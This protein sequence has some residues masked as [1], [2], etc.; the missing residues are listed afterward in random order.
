[1]LFG[2][3]IQIQRLIEMPQLCDSRLK[4]VGKALGENNQ[5]IG[6]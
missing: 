3:L 1:M 2:K 6:L 4:L 5:A